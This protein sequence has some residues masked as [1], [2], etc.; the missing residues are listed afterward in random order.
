MTEEVKGENKKWAAIRI[1]TRGATEA[2]AIHVICILKRRLKHVIEGEF[3]N[4][5]QWKVGAMFQMCFVGYTLLDTTSW[6][7]EAAK[8]SKLFPGLGYEIRYELLKSKT[9]IENAK[10]VQMCNDM[11]L[12]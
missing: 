12:A 4:E 11:L 6:K 3:V 8:L 7:A 1:I 5:G 10:S 9:T 2:A